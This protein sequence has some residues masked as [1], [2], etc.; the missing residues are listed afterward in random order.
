MYFKSNYR[1]EN[2]VF[3]GHYTKFTVFSYG[4]LRWDDVVFII[5]SFFEPVSIKFTLKCSANYPLSCKYFIRS[6]RAFRHFY[7]SFLLTS[8]AF[9]TMNIQHSTS[10]SRVIKALCGRGAWSSL[11]GHWLLSSVTGSYKADTMCN[12]QELTNKKMGEK[13]DIYNLSTKKRW[14]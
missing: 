5:H 3:K 2:M 11:W 10:E 4:R 1:K 7:L 6:D 9:N 14:N 13:K 8:Q 12:Q